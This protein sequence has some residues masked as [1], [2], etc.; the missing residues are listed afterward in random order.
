MSQE[1]LSICIPTY[2]RAHLL[3]PLLGVLAEQIP[4]ENQ[5]DVVIYVS[6][7]GSGDA[8]PQVVADFQKQHGLSV[9]FTRNA[10]NLGLSKN[11]LKVMGMGKGRFIWALG[12]DEIIAPKALTRLL[13]SLRQL[14]PGF[15]L[16]F[17]T[18]YK[19]P[20]PKPGLYP[21]YRE[22]ARECLKLD[23][24]HAMAEHTL[25]SSNVYRSAHFDPVFAEANIDT[26]FPH[27]FG[28][29]K[30]LLK[31]ELSVLVPDY[32]VISTRKDGRGAPVDGIWADLDQCWADYL[33]WLRD[34]MRMPELDPTAAGRV[35]RKNMIANIRAHPI[36][37]L[38]TNWRA[39]F[40]PSAY[41]YL[42]TRI[43]GART[44]GPTKS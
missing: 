21:N 17:D 29:M 32:P 36:R 34:E 9:V 39:I 4:Q 20:L 41:R 33:G 2:N 10:T 24:A 42:Y 19:W 18:N 40:Q 26:W 23:N 1:L 11:L 14:D 13:G 6:D 3:K 16:M 15:V 30:P 22:F 12:D 8:T 25:L 31:H 5:K 44:Q 37:Y 38:R 35:A 7:N 28:F 43:F 27:M